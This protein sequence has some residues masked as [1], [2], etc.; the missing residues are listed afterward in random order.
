MLSTKPTGPHCES[1][2]M[3][4]YIELP[5][6][7]PS[8]DH[9][10]FTRVYTL[11]PFTGL[12]SQG[13]YKVSVKIWKFIK[14]K[15]ELIQYNTRKSKL[16]DR[17]CC[18]PKC[19]LCTGW[20]R[21]CKRKSS[22]CWCCENTNIRYIFTANDIKKFIWDQVLQKLILKKL[23]N[24]HKNKTIFWDDLYNKIVLLFFPG[25][26]ATNLLA[27][28]CDEAILKHYKKYIS[29]NLTETRIAPY[30]NNSITF[31]KKYVT[32]STLM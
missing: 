7:A 25:V 2:T 28:W 26:I 1:L 20:G 4:S 21:G 11:T 32:S 9:N 17:F 31:S 3:L 29:W 23:T 30:Y 6:Q 16:S 22:L 18:T 8:Y 10:L 15:I 13:V 12:K 19:L 24:I 14:K 27:R 5:F